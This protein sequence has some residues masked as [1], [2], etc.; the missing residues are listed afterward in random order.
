MALAAATAQGLAI[1][2]TV[3]RAIEALE[4]DPATAPVA[5]H[6]GLILALAAGSGVARLASRFAIV[7]AAQRVEHALRTTLHGALQRFPPALLARHP[8]GDLMARATSDVGAVRSLT[9]FGVVSFVSTVLAFVGAVAAMLALDPW[10]T[11][12][13][14]A[15]YPLLI[16]L[17]QGANAAIHQ[18]TEAAQE[19]LGRLSSRVQ[20]HL[21][22]MSVVRAYTM[23]ARAAAVFDEANADYRARSLALARAQ[24][25]FVPL[26]GLVAGLGALIVLWL[27]GRAV[28]R[29]GLS[30]GALVAFTG[31]LAYLAWP[32]LALGFTLSLLRRGLTSMARVQEV[33]AAAPVPEPGGPPAG[34]PSPPGL[35]FAG[36]SF[37]YPGRPP[38]LREV[39][40]EVE[41]GRMVAVVGPTGG[42]KSTLGLVLARLWEPPPGTVFVGGR[43][44]TTLARGDLRARL[45]CV[46]QDA[47]LFSRSVADNVTLGRA[48]LDLAR[49]RE[50][51]RVAGVAGEV[52]RLPQGWD[53]VVGERGLTVSGGQRQRLALARALAGDPPVLV[54]DDVFA[55]VDLATEEA[56]L[57]DLRRAAA[58]RT[59]LVM[60]HRLRAARAADR[61]VVLDGGR[62]VEQGT[63]EALLAAGG[64]YA[65]LWRRQ[66]LEEE[67]ARA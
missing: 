4:A 35:R 39:S 25:A 44:V 17:G 43:D 42:G 5:F 46:P 40:F 36:L 10:L 3:Q 24:A 18:R 29:G 57:A 13:A 34:L 67:M 14:L 26:T 20:E 11:L 7:G 50:A 30:L 2:R 12:A 28:A 56:I 27:G 48:G 19:S 54:L 63:H 62:V 47:F 1:P 65:R 32:T 53:T 52:E 66:Q 41:P 58:G 64:L 23:E 60:T 38:V 9:G 31:Y 61:V 6:V 21:G 8:T 51:A 37:T 15:P 55:S 33:I 22:A 59:V 16:L 45:G 49:V